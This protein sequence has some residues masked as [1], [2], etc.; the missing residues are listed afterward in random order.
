MKKFSLV[1][2]AS[3]TCVLLALFNG[4]TKDFTSIN[5]N[6]NAPTVVPATNVLARG[7]LS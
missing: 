2:I 4:C 7:I 1:K 5:Q 6:P 3:I